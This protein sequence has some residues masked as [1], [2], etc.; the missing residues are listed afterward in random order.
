MRRSHEDLPLQASPSYDFDRGYKV[1]YVSQSGQ[2]C[3]WAGPSN[4]SFARFTCPLQRIKKEDADKIAEQL[5]KDHPEAEEIRTV[6]AYV[7][8]KEHWGAFAVLGP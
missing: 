4:R 2:R 1:V 7:D 6:R 8:E 5:T 3:V